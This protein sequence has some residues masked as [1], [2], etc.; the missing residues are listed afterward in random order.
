M[1][2]LGE[3]GKQGGRGKRAAMEEERVRTA[4]EEGGREWETHCFD[5]E[6]SE[7]GVSER[8]EGKGETKSTSR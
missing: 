2:E 8:K 6:E 1:G 4:S 5:V 7:T 3:K